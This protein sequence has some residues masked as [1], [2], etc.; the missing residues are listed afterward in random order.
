MA[1]KQYVT[2]DLSSLS[3]LELIALLN[4]FCENQN[5]Y[6]KHGTNLRAAWDHLIRTGEITNVTS[7]IGMPY[8]SHRPP[9]EVINTMK[10]F[11]TPKVEEHTIV[12][13]LKNNISF[14]NYRPKYRKMT[15]EKAD[16]EYSKFRSALLTYLNKA[17][18]RHGL[19]F[20]DKKSKK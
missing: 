6:I 11:V 10:K 4:R 9:D 14:G 5:K 19:I 20:I 2:R 3:V 15:K 18:K 8:D 7:R 16:K 1:K 13:M 12:S 17:W